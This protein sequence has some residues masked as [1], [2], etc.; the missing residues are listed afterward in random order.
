MTTGGHTY[1]IEGIK[2]VGTINQ[3]V[4]WGYY[5]TDII[6]DI[7]GSVSGKNV[8]SYITPSMPHL[9]DHSNCEY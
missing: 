2:Y 5:K 4:K 6:H 7:D 3:K 8:E 1:E 9:K